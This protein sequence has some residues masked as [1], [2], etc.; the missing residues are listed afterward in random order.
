M[1]QVKNLISSWSSLLS[2]S[3][4]SRIA[5]LTGCDLN[6]TWRPVRFFGACSE[7]S[8]LFL[9]LSSCCFSARICC[10]CRFFSR[11]FLSLSFSAFLTYSLGICSTAFRRS[12]SFDSRSE[13]IV[14]VRGFEVVSNPQSEYT[15]FTFKFSWFSSFSCW[16]CLIPWLAFSFSSSILLF[17]C[18]VSICC[19]NSLM[20]FF[21]AEVFSS[22]FSLVWRNVLLSSSKACS[23]S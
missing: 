11:L 15:S 2:S 21:K 1:F 6:I 22:I 9:F 14:R 19:S 12:S 5:R 23:V 13:S 4:S 18:S 3:L 8:M 10:S 16:P 17:S 20:F 7:R